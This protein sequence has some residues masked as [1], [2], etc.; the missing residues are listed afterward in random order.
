MGLFD[1]LFGP[2]WC[3]KVNQYM[4]N[5]SIP[6]EERIRICILKLRPTASYS[7]IAQ[8]LPVTEI[9]KH[10]I[11]YNNRD[12]LE[13][14]ATAIFMRKGMRMPIA[15]SKAKPD[16]QWTIAVISDSGMLPTNDELKYRRFQNENIIVWE[17]LNNRGEKI[18]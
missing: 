16:K 5:E 9:K 2:S 3:E 12:E 14:L 1:S 18:T 13:N 11:R 8:G 4:L 6:I 15:L 7:E 17:P 10:L